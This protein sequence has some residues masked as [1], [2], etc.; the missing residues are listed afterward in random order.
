MTGAD[1]VLPA[2][3]D[4]TLKTLKNRVPE[5]RLRTLRTV[6]TELIQLYWNIGHEIR[7]QQEQQGWGSK[8]VQQLAEDLRAEFPDMT[9]LSRSNLQYMRAF[10]GA[11]SS[12]S[13]VKQAGGQLRGVTSLPSWTSSTTKQRASGTPLLPWSTDGHATCC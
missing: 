13:I 1:V 6:N 9:G 4:Q 10:A 11:W 8:V 12:E 2:G 3:Y 7:T 5:A